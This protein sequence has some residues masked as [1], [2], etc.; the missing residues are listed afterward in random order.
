MKLPNLFIALDLMAVSTEGLEAITGRSFNYSPIHSIPASFSSV[1]AT[2][3]KDVVN[4][5]GAKVSVA[6]LAALPS[7]GFDCTHT[8]IAFVLS[9]HL[10]MALSMLTGMFSMALGMCLVPSMSFSYCAHP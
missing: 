8:H 3:V 6:T 4:L 10:G 1:L 9:V 5:K 2:T 7:K